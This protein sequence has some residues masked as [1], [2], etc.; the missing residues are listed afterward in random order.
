MKSKT[1][2]EKQLRKKSCPELIETIICSKKNKKW[3]EIASIL[4]RPKRKKMEVNLD[5][6]EKE[7]KNNET[8]VVPGKVLSQGEINKKINI[9]AVSFSRKAEE[10]L[11]KSGCRISKIIEEIKKNPDA[12]EIKIIK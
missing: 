11:L 9:V 10:K 2:I 5:R 1:E 12:K 7:S 6:I 8:I 3:R 4:S